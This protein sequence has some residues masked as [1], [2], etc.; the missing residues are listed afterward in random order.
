MN[1]RAYSYA[2][3]AVKSAML[4]RPWFSLATCLCVTGCGTLG[5][6]AVIPSD[7]DDSARDA[8][9]GPSSLD[10]VV[11][12]DARMDAADVA[13][14]SDASDAPEFNRDAPP[15]DAAPDVG[16][17]GSACAR[18]APELTGLTT[19]GVAVSPDRTAFNT[20]V[21]LYYVAADG[22]LRAELRTAAMA[23]QCT[24][25]LGAPPGVTLIGTPATAHRREHVIVAGRNASGELEY[26]A[27]FA[28]NVAGPCGE[29]MGE[30][31]RVPAPSGGARWVSAPAARSHSNFGASERVFVAGQTDRGEL[32]F[33]DRGIGDGGPNGPWSLS[34]MLSPASACD[35][36][37]IRP[38]VRPMGPDS[39]VAL[40]LERETSGGY[41]MLWFVQTLT[42]SM[43]EPSPQRRSFGSSL[44][45]TPFSAHDFL[46]PL[47][48]VD[49]V[50]FA[51]GPTVI[52]GMTFGSDVIPTIRYAPIS[53]GAP[54]PELGAESPLVH[55]VNG[56]GAREWLGS[57][58]ELYV[59]AQSPSMPGRLR[60]AT[61]PSREW[62]TGTP[63]VWRESPDR[64]E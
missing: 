52:F 15:Q 21:R 7:R 20:V 3:H 51:L 8:T 47:G 57:V 59:I 53:L 1:N 55:V 46:A 14:H 2:R 40:S 5:A 6:V 48:W 50:A 34:T 16:D 31:D 12:Y 45:T 29:A 23:R 58:G 39:I 61:T 43:F 32:Y 19:R 18:T 64:L 56:P 22:T 49:A 25:N 35:A 24:Q 26:W 60:F 9:S 36:L 42:D 44:P 37:H 62:F 27:R 63:V 41:A 11:T 38:Q 54:F 17:S 10:D 33:V 28:T 13:L 4:V 30:W